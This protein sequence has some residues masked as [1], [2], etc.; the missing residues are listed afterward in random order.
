M[1]SL[2][3]KER[4]GK[5]LAELNNSDIDKF[6]E[7]VRSETGSGIIVRTKMIQGEK[8]CPNCGISIWNQSEDAIVVCTFCLFRNLITPRSK[9]YPR[10][11]LLNARFVFS[12]I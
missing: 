10:M 2:E 11:P 5:A 6:I 8:I 9:Y 3:E 7:D 12:E 4:Q 1:T